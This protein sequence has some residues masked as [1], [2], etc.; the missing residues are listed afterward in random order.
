MSSTVCRLVYELLQLKHSDASWRFRSLDEYFYVFAGQRIHRVALYDHT[1]SSKNTSVIENEIE[2]KVGDVVTLIHY[3]SA[4][5]RNFTMNGYVLAK[6]ERTNISGYVPM[7]KL[8]NQI[9]FADAYKK[10]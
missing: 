2:L 3:E 6:N 9:L 1:P 10:S 7:Y 5:V 8:M 4:N